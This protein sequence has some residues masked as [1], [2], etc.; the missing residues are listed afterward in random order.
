VD[1]ALPMRVIQGPGHFGR[2]PQGILDRK[3][4]LAREPLPE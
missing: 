1:H 2:D 4:L 3:L